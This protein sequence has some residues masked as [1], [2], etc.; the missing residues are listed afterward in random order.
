MVD[1]RPELADWVNAGGIKLYASMCDPAT[2]L[3]GDLLGDLVTWHKL[4]QGVDR[5][6]GKAMLVGGGTTVGVSAMV[7]AYV[8]GF[9]KIMCFGLDSS[10]AKDQHH[11]YPQALNDGE[12][13]LDCVVAGERFRAAPWMVKQSEDWR[14]TSIELLKAGCEITVMGEGLIAA[15]ARSM[16]SEFVAIDGLYWPSGDIEARKSVLGTQADLERYIGL[17]PA[18]RVAIQAG[19][20]VGVWPKE[21]AKHFREVHTFEPDARNFACL[22]RNVTEGNVHAYREALGSMRERASIRREAGN[23]GASS[24]V[25]GDEFPVTTI[26]A[27]GLAEVDLIQLDVEG[28]ELQALEGAWNTI[29]AC[30][31]LIVLELKGH[32]ARYGYTDEEV[33]QAMIGHGYRR[34]GVAHR[35]VIYQHE[36]KLQ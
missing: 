7:L 16:S 36:G 26:D 23:C 2:L 6:L 19:G 33:D 3:K 20:N 32:G 9:R 10:Y 31:P 15:I 17:C 34:L 18:H 30:H 11:A 21:L 27:L 14:E 5:V 28:F 25:Q 8:M 22:E 35:D 12:R 24:I 1:A 4:T 29:R 13:I